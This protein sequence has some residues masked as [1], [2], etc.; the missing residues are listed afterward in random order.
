MDAPISHAVVLPDRNFE[1][2]LNAVRPYMQAFE[3]VSVV[4]S[5]AGNDLN[6]FRNVTAVQAPDVWFNDDALAHIRRA[7]PMVVRVDMIYTSTPAQLQAELAQRVAQDDRYGERRNHPQH[8]FDRFTLEWM[9]DARPTRIVRPFSS[10]TDRSPDIYEG[11]DIQTYRGA[12]IFA[13]AAGTVTR[14]IPDNDALHYGAYVQVLT[15]FDGETYIVT[16]AG[17]QD[18]AVQDNQ[19][20]N[21]GDEIA[22]AA[23]DAV[24]IVVQ[25]PPNG[26]SGFILPNV[27]DPLLMIY[28]QGMRLQPTV[29]ALR[30][31]SR[32]STEGD[33]II[34]QVSAQ[35]RL[36]TQ[37]IHGRTLAKLGVDGQWLR[38]RRA[39]TNQAYAAAWFLRAVGPNDPTEAITGVPV[40]GMNLDIDHHLGRPDPAALGNIGWVRLKF[41]VSLNPT[42]PDGHPNRYGNT[43]VRFTFDRYRP[44]LEGYQRAG[45][46][47]ILVLTHQTFGEGQGYVWPQMDSGKWRDLSAKYAAIVQQTAQLFRNTGLIYAYQ[48]WN[49]QDT[50]PEDARAAVPMPVADYAH[51]LGEAIQAIRQ[52]DSQTL[53]ISGGHVGGPEVAAAYAAQTLARLP[54]GLRPNG[55]AWHPY[56]RGPEDHPYSIH[57]TIS[58]AIRVYRNT[59]PGTPVWITE[60]GI[61]NAQGNDSIAGQ[62]TQYATGFLNNIQQGFPGEVAA[63]CW[64]AWADGMDNGYGLIRSDGSPRQ[65]L[66]DSY[67]K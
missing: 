23:G 66:Y 33:N 3:R 7:Y 27:V 20:V 29:E 56:G 38:V 11:F 53:I 47:I 39:G 50:K 62:V 58:H 31:R 18:I 59:L 67:L 8:I 15:Q 9:T 61:L 21:V 48:I 64:Y 12:K 16:Y 13:A 10:R 26:M 24:K 63:A 55:L 22:R 35:D 44:I 65:P 6:R 32:P 2:W 4:R 52:V 19:R 5:P 51:L 17:L 1:D 42:L 57:G 40:P 30:I 54:G 41:N 49:E 60:W 28:W 45:K 25:N 36:E 43:D 14:I 34:G 37:E 46:K